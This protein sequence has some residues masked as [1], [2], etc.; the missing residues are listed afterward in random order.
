MG[1]L[2][3]YASP[4]NSV[5]AELVPASPSVLRV[6]IFRLPHA[7]ADLPFYATPGAAGMDLRAAIDA[8]I[9]LNPLERRLI[10]TGWIL[11]LPAGYEAQVR[12]RSGLSIKHGIS[13]A[14]CVGTIDSDYRDELKVPLINLSQEA[15]TLQ[16]GERVAQLIVAPVIQ[17]QWQPVEAVS[18]VEGRSGGFG[19]TGL[20]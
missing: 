6:E 2:T 7:P 3:A 8:P 18:S 13:L 1:P 20:L 4:E 19:S 11:L 9:T 16:P 17:V 15:Y 5:S 10:P 14:N 12:P